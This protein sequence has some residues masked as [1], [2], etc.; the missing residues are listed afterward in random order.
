MSRT[1]DRPVGMRCIDHLS[2]SSSS[3]QAQIAGWPM[4]NCDGWW[5]CRMGDWR[6]DRRQTSWSLPQP[7]GSNRSYSQLRPGVGGV[8]GMGLGTGKWAEDGPDHRLGLGTLPTHDF[9][10]WASGLIYFTLLPH[11]NTHIILTT[12]SHKYYMRAHYKADH[13][14]LTCESIHNCGMSFPR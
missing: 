9:T 5:Q 2:F 13:K 7:A 11:V 14:L 1:T 12:S 4:G 8:G 6:P 3:P 10:H